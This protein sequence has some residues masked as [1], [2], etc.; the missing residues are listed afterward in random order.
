MKFDGFDLVFCALLSVLA[1]IWL[2]Q[3][4]VKASEPDVEPAYQM[5]IESDPKAMQRETERLLKDGWKLHGPTEASIV[6]GHN[7]QELLIIQVMTK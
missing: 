7:G 2:G 3:I 5:L 6:M 4:S 1:G